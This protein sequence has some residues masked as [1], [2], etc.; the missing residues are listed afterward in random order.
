MKS[1]VWMLALATAACAQDVDW[2]ATVNDFLPRLD[3]EYVKNASSTGQ[4]E[5]ELAGLAERRADDR[6][7]KR[8]AAAAK[9]D[10]QQLQAN[11]VNVLFAK[12]LSVPPLRPEHLTILREY[13]SMT[14]SEVALAYKRHVLLSHRTAVALARLQASRGRDRDIT[15]YALESLPALEHHAHMAELLANG[16]RLGL[17]PDLRPAAP[18]AGIPQQAATAVR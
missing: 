8:L 17:L 6:E 9:R 12:G 7:V 11:L 14:G 16:Q 10:H 4:L 18:M 13:D 3:N 2:G 5:V 1:L 15:A